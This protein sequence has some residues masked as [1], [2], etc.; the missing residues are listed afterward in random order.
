MTRIDFYFNAPTKSEV[1]R[2]LAGKAF[3]AGQH[4]LVY[5]P[6]GVQARELESLFWS[7]RPL[8]FLPHVCCGDALATQTPILIGAVP[9][10]LARADVLIN[11]STEMPAFFARFERVLDIVGTD[12]ADKALGRDRYRYFRER[13]YELAVHDLASAE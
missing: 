13:G 10:E 7:A 9:D 2:K 8:G 4:A 12:D 5:T 6:D 11:V 1:A 3:K